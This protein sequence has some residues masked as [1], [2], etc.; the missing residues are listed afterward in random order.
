[1]KGTTKKGNKRSKDEASEVG[2]GSGGFDDPCLD[3]AAIGRRSYTKDSDIAKDIVKVMSKFD[4]DVKFKDALKFLFSRGIPLGLFV[5]GTDTA[6]ST[7]ATATASEDGVV[8]DSNVDQG[9]TD[10]SGNSSAK[11]SKKQQANSQNATE[12]TAK[13]NKV[14]Q[15]IFGPAGLR[16]DKLIRYLNNAWISC[17]GSI[18]DYQNFIW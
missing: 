8:D 18:L 4:D 11:E 2:A 5:R 17:A 14:I 12:A 3:E 6:A 7:K 10:I 15:N 16:V 13:K 9:S 1:M